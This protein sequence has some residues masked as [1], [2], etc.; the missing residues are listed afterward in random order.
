MLTDITE[1][2]NAEIRLAVQAEELQ[3]SGRE[4]EEFACLAS[5][6]LQEP[7]RVVASYCDI[8]ARRY[9]DRL[10]DDGRE[11]IANAVDG[12]SRMQSLID[13]LV[14]YS[15]A[16]REELT[17][18]PFDLDEA[19]EHARRSLQALITENQAVIE[20][21]DLPRIVGDQAMIA[22]VFHN[23]IGNAIKFRAEAPPLVRIS[24]ERDKDDWIV[25]VTDNG[26]GIETEF[27]E[28][29][30]GIF[31]RPDTLKDFPGN[32]LGLAMCRRIV[33]RHG[34]RIWATVAEEPGATIRFTIPIS[35]VM[36]D[37]AAK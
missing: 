32:G 7:L 31:Q 27:A 18:A 11:F 25:S 10:D 5:Q 22:Q 21:C 14:T 9:A 30:F 28:R 15:R 16:G 23:L 1:R 2:K 26:I 36:S 13:D 6:D 37:R 35:P 33:T 12:A 34:G 4:L 29:I 20:F 17:L 8:I 24:A 3:R 19:V